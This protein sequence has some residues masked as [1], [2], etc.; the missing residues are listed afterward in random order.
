MNTQTERVLA[1][2]RTYP[3]GI[4]QVDFLLPDVID[5]GAPIT[6]IGARILEL[7]DAGHMIVSGPRRDK[8]VTY[9]LLHG[10]TEETATRGGQSLAG[11]AN[12]QA[13]SAPAVPLFEVPSHQPT[14]DELVGPQCAINDDIDT[15]A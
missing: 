9:K 14:F 15:A 5:G 3:R 1:A 4:T 12:C 10:D 7:R 11:R 2:L 8:C 13:T 6:R